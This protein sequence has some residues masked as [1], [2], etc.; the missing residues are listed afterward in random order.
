MI[1]NI[2]KYELLSII[3]ILLESKKYDNT[4]PDIIKRFSPYIKDLE[5]SIDNISEDIE[6]ELIE[7]NDINRTIDNITIHLLYLKKII[8]EDVD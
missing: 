1:Y 3:E 7:N 2:Y 4:L 8:K 5:L 6:I